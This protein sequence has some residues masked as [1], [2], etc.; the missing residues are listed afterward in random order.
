M[1]N[2]TLVKLAAGAAGFAAGVHVAAKYRRDVDAARNRYAALRRVAHTRCGP[3]EYAMVGTG[4]PLLLVHGAG[5]GYDQALDF[6]LPFADDGFRLIAMSR[7]GYLGTPLPEDAS[8]AAQADAHAALLDALGLPNAA[9]LGAS[10]GAPSSLQ[11]ALRHRDRCAAL[12]LVV[13][14][15]YA[16]RRGGAAPLTTPPGTR[17][18]FETALRFDFLYWAATRL[19]RKAMVRGILA[20]PVDVLDQIDPE[21][22]ARVDAMLTHILPVSDR[23]PG[24]LNDARVCSALPRYDLERITAPTLVTSV[25]DDLFGTYDIAR[26]T[27]QHIPGARFLGFRSGGH[28]WLGHHRRHLAEIA[29]FLR[30]AVAAPSRATT[31]PQPSV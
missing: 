6:G 12:V 8:P 7:F 18:L 31:V 27:A 16:P 1:E 15:A 9:I 2:R 5:G 11:F 13:P 22:I 24:L 10:A 20:T 21:E 14:A 3:I 19:A 23:R 25:A 26:Y 28:V 30:E 17:T 29:A 4:T